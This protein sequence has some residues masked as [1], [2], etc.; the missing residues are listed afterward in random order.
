VL[1]AAVRADL[2]DDVRVLVKGSRS[3]R[4]ERVVDA[5]LPGPPAVV[6]TVAASNIAE[7]VA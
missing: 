1:A 5:L 7:G 4:L 2:A 6:A 3:N